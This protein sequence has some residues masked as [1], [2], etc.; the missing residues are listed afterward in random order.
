VTGQSPLVSCVVP[1]YNGECY[2]AEALDSIFA[3][4]YR[5]L[6]VIVVDDGSTDGTAA[7]L[8]SFGQR[9]T[10]LHQ[11][12]AGHAVARN[13]GV[14]AAQGEYLAFL[15]A[16]DL[17][18]PEKLAR[19]VERFRARP[20]LEV[21]VTLIQNFWMPDV[22]AEAAEFRGQRRGGPLPGYSPVTLLAQRALFER[23]GPFD[24]ALMH[25]ADTAWFLRAEELGTVIEL[26]S[27]VLVYRR[28]HASSF[29]REHVASSQA[30]YLEIVK[31]ALDRRRGRQAGKLAG[32]DAR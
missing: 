8:A 5:P 1:V 30:E 26:L 15:D 20:E 6:E 27:E 13:R 2:L 7:L 28:M 12:N 21:S 18:H 9:I 23:L 19:Q 4:T 25:G 32:E 11:A 24:P 17:W 14:G 22:G 16:D 31:A 10:A 29:S 3:Q